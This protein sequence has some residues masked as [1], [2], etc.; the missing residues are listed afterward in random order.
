MP[1]WYDVNGI[2]ADGCECADDGTSKSCNT[3]TGLGSL[4]NGGSVSSTGDLPLI[5]ESDYLQVTFGGPS[6]VL[7]YHPKISFTVN[8][9]N[10]FVFDV[11]SSCG[12]TFPACTDNACVSLTTWEHFYTGG[13]P[14]QPTEFVPVP[15]VGTVTI[16]VYRKTGGSTCEN[17]TLLIND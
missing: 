11:L 2:Y 15:N 7:A 14:T 8:P 17:Y 12:V 3:A 4:V 13:D 5:T 1:G 10:D 6:N 9:N 16:R